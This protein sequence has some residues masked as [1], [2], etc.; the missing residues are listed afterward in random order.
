MYP[1][2]LLYVFALWK[3]DHHIINYGLILSI[4]GGAISA[5]H[6]LLQLGVVPN[7]PCSAIGYSVSCSARFVLNFGY[8]TI[9]MMALAAFGLVATVLLVAKSQ[10][11]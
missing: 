7:L 5:Y 1:Q 9:P 11:K 3:K 4:V 10:R 2:V 8:I 6:Y